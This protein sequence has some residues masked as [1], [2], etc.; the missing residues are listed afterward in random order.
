ME[1]VYLILLLGIL[2]N[3]SVLTVIF[4]DIKEV[5]SEASKTLNSIGMDIDN[6][7][8]VASSFLNRVDDIGNT[9]YVIS[10]IGR[11]DNIVENLRDIGI[12]IQEE[13]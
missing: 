6:I 7:D 12:I 5:L 1:I 4:R 2:I 8:Y 3:L 9:D 13:K 10:L 11:M